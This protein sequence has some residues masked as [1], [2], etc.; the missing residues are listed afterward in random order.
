MVECQLIGRGIMDRRIT[1]AMS[2]IPRH[3]FVNPQDRDRAYED[4]PLPIGHG[5]TISQ[6]YMVAKAA[7]LLKLS[8]AEKVLEVGAGCGYQASVLSLLCKSV[9]A[10]E[11]HAELVA[12]A[13]SNLRR[14]QV[15][16][17]QVVWGDGKLGWVKEAPYDR[18]L[19]SCAA[20]SVTRAWEEQLVTGGILVFPQDAPENQ[21]LWKYVKGTE[22]WASQEEIFGVRFVPLL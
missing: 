21:I 12:C 5:Q 17:V 20:K 3:F 16:N 18:I 10:I 6:P 14:A 15:A 8:G 22:G 19:V 7:E 11:W 9:V 2:Q 13:Q 1:N 4:H